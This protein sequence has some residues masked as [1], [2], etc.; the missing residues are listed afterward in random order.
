MDSSYTFD[1]AASSFSLPEAIDSPLVIE[2]NKSEATPPI[3]FH[4]PAPDT[5]K[6]GLPE[7]VLEETSGGDSS[8]I[9]KVNGLK[10][11]YLHKG[12]MLL[13]YAV[14][15]NIRYPKLLEMNDLKDAPLPFDMPVYLEKKLTSGLHETHTVANGETMLMIAQKEGMQ[16]RRLSSLNLLYPNE[17][18]A[19]GTVLQL[20]KQAVKRP[21]LRAQEMPA[22]LQNAILPDNTEP[23]QSAD[24]VAI[25]RTKP[26]VK[27]APKPSAAAGARPPAAEPKAAPPVAASASFNNIP[28]R[29][30]TP[31]NKI[32]PVQKAP[33]PELKQEETNDEELARMKADLDKVVY[34]DD[35]KL[36]V[37]EKTKTVV[38]AKK[39]AVTEKP[40]TA[41]PVKK[42]AVTEAAK[43]RAAT[44]KKYYTIK[45]GETAFS[46][47]KKNNITLDQ[48]YKM[49]DMDAGDIKV[50]KTIIVKE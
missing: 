4:S 36:P 35:S 47:A 17:E 14:A 13:S 16:M 46:I 29:K 1:N 45:K 42:E 20:Q 12:E 37:A 3:V 11:I 10:A 48:L 25:D 44:A 32:P 22:H 31:V 34:A 18:P 5:I 24:Y 9:E 19:T 23:K 8:K 33:E 49:N 27:P 41:E 43:P 26:A 50:G 15:N 21:D 28:P 30:P 38:L 7:M 39:D 2:E 40:K 6:K